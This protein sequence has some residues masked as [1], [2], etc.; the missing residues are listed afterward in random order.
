MVAAIEA[1]RA[2]I[3]AGIDREALQHL[4]PPGGARNALDCALWDLEA[5]RSGKPVWQLAGVDAAESARHD[6]H[7]RRRGARGDGRR[8]AQFRAR[9][10][11]QD[12][13]D[14]RTR[15]RH[16]A[17]ARGARGAAD[18]VDR[19][20]CEPG[21]RHRL[22]RQAARGARRGEGRARR[23][24]ARARA[25]SRSRRLLFADSARRRRKRAVPR[26]HTEAHR[27]VSRRQHQARQVRRPHRRSRDGAPGARTRA[28]GDGRQHGR[29]EL[30]DGAGIRGRAALRH[31]RS[32][33]ADLP[34][35]RPRRRR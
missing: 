20:R 3:E 33:R 30:G 18:D 19:R 23:T 8:R 4:L 6:V 24:A 27:P 26:R 17:R 9:A 25:R 14:R 34:R 2:A 1:N 32:R 10:C 22:A 15:S 29:H 11:D 13:A 31:R 16:R 5:H 35:Q 12:E 21:L 7:A 28:Q